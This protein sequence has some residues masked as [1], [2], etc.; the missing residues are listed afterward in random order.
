MMYIFFIDYLGPICVNQQ[1][2]AEI[3]SLIKFWEL[4]YQCY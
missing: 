2:W 1:R 3:M 4:N